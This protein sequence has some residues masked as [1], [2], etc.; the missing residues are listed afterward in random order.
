MLDSVSMKKEKISE[1]V[2]IVE[3]GL[4]RQIVRIVDRID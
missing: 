3:E 2:N 1:G 4:F